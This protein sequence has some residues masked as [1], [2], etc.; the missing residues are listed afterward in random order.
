MI[1]QG[2]VASL[3][4]DTT[5]YQVVVRAEDIN[6]GLPMYLKTKY[7]FH[8]R[9]SDKGNSFRTELVRELLDFP[10]D[11]RLEATQFSV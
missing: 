11:E 10:L 3:P 9:P 4:P 7:A 6:Q 2:D 8:A 5:K 1:I